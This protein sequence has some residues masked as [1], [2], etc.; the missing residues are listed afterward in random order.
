ES[1]ILPVP[2]PT[3]QTHPDPFGWSPPAPCPSVR[4]HSERRKFHNPLLF[5]LWRPQRL[6]FAGPGLSPPRWCGPSIKLPA[7]A[8][9]LPILGLLTL[10]DCNSQPGSRVSYRSEISYASE[11][12]RRRRMSLPVLKYGTDLDATETVTPVR[13][14]RPVRA[15]RCLTEK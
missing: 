3:K 15:E 1:S 2:G 5:R 10:R 7:L 9:Q 11:G 8:I 14:L 4:R 13:G 6:Q 12:L